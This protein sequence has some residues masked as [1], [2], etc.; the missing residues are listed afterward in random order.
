[1]VALLDAV[2]IDSKCEVVLQNLDVIFTHGPNEKVRVPRDAE[3]SGA[4]DRGAWLARQRVP[5]TAEA[6]GQGS[7]S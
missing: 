6:V 5:R 1:L 7:V 4:A 3:L 2:K